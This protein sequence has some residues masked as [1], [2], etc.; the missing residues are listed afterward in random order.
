M[1]KLFLLLT[2]LVLSVFSHGQNGYVGG[3]TGF[4]KGLGYENP[5]AN[6]TA[7][8][9]ISPSSFFGSA[10]FSIAS[11]RKIETGNGWSINGTAHGYWHPKSFLLGP[12]LS[13]THLYTSQWDKGATHAEFGAGYWKPHSNFRFMA[14]YVMPWG[15]P[16]NALQG[17]T[18]RFEIGASSRLMFRAS[19]SFY[20][21]HVTLRPD[22]SGQ[23]G[24]AAQFSLFWRFR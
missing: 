10:E 16:Q 6:L 21:Y 13:V 5:D 11:E 18:T 20:D 8:V 7:G 9:E 14:D 4:T 12:G 3:G 24:D 23:W 1:K 2:V 17:I 22:L 15:D 19:Y